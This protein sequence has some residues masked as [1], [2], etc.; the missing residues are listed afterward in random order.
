MFVHIKVMPEY[1]S[2]N[3]GVC[4]RPPA[5]LNRR[6]VATLYDMLFRTNIQCSYVYTLHLFI[7]IQCLY[8]AYIFNRLHRNILY[9]CMY[10][11][12]CWDPAHAAEREGSLAGQKK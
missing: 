9:I 7:C 3:T 2:H 5:L 8:N 11:L 10:T 12:T 4:A 6:L 1:L